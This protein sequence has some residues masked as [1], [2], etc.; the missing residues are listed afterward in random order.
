MSKQKNNIETMNKI[1]DSAIVLFNNNGFSGASIS[2]IS[3]RAGVAK[4]NLYYYFKNK[5]ELYLH[6]AKKCIEDFSLY[7][8]ENLKE[9][10]DNELLALELLRLRITF[11]DNYPQY[12]IFFL[13]ILAKKPDHLSEEL[14][15]IRRTFKEKNLNLFMKYLSKIPLGKGVKHEDIL[16][17][18]S[19]LQNHTAIAAQTFDENEN[20]NDR[21]K[22]ILRI[23]T[24]FI[25]GLKEDM[26]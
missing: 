14:F 6:C 26:E 9:G 17:F 13:N 5:D 25:N 16:T 4:G 7:L 22:A 1:V 11:F 19:L 24:I 20:N 3:N 23:A 12:K 10:D 15:E 8:T 21:G 2:Q 18:I